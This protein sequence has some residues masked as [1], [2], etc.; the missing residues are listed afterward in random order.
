MSEGWKPK[1]APGTKLPW[2][3]FLTLGERERLLE[4]W[5]AKRH[6]QELNKGR[7]AIV[8]RAIHRAKEASKR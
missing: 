7:A 5:D 3:D 1:G 6:W 8:N 2:R 4:I